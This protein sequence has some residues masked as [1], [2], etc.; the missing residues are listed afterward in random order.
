M[1]TPNITASNSGLFSVTGTDANGCTGTANVTVTINPNPTITLVATN[2]TICSYENS[3]INASGANAYRWSTN[4]NGNSILVN[5]AGLYQATGTDINGCTA[6]SNAV[7]ITVNQRPIIGAVSTTNT[8]NCLIDDGTLLITG[9]TANRSYLLEYSYNGT[10]SSKTQT[11]NA[12]GQL[13][14]SNLQAG[15]YINLI[16][17]DQVTSCTS[18]MNL[19]PHQILTPPTPVLAI[20]TSSG[21]NICDYDLVTLTANG[22]D[23]YLWNNGAT[24]ASIVVPSN[25]LNNVIGTTLGCTATLSLQPFSGPGLLR[26]ATT[27]VKN[28]ACSYLT[29]G[30][31][32]VTA[33]GGIGGYNYRWT[34]SNNNL[35]SISSLSAGTYSLTI[36]DRNGCSVSSNFTITTP[37]PLSLTTT[38]TDLKCFGDESGQIK[39]TQTNG[40]TPPYRYSLDGTLFSPTGLLYTNLNAGTYNLYMTDANACSFTSPNL[41]VDQPPAIIVTLS[42]SKDTIELGDSLAIRVQILNKPSNSTAVW[43]PTET[44]NCTSCTRNVYAKPQNTTTYTLRITDTDKGCN[45]TDA[46]TIYVDKTRNLYIPNAFT[47]NADGVNDVFMVYAAKGIKTIK[48]FRIFD[49]WGERLYDAY[50]LQP[51]DELAGWNGIFKGKPMPPDVYVY[52]IEVEYLDN[53]TEP[54]KGSLNLLR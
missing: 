4:A 19:G 42:T 5:T 14:I 34:P 27:E 23:A 37:S 30:S 36:S 16:V 11:T 32:S 46:V 21:P 47:P 28:V 51:N 12:L 31:I 8:T 3:T 1:I 39:I 50:N 20:Q 33:S 49:R 41:V 40:G 25:Q 22:A 9:L 18:P 35:A 38:I 17:T 54:H 45:A 53:Y 24:T 26:I 13:L 48:T 29:N 43:S 6:V 44:L 52:Y 15:I 2:T 10:P 7:S